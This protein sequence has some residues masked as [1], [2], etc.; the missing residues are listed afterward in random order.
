MTWCSQRVS[1]QLPDKIRFS[2]WTNLKSRS[3]RS[4]RAM[5][6]ILAICTKSSLG[7][8]TYHPITGFPKPPNR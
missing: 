1:Q 5:R 8:S 7:Q 6:N 3:N 4:T 2:S